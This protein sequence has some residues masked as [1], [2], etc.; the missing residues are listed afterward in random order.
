M[1]KSN[2]TLMAFDLN[3]VQTVSAIHAWDM[4]K[5]VAEHPDAVIFK[6]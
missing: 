3:G 6:R 1:A 4:A 5:F 2:Y